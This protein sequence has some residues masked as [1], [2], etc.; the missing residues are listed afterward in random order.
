MRLTLVARNTE[1]VGARLQSRTARQKEAV[2]S[3]MGRSGIRV[4]AGVIANAPRKTGYLASRTT[5]RRTREGFNYGV[6]YY[7]EDF[8]G[9]IGRDGRLI[10]VFYP[11]LLWGGT[12]VM[13]G[14]DWLTPALEA[15]RPIVR[16]N[17]ARILAGTPVE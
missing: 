11:I 5:L 9:Q 16:G 2:K 15:E 14:R 17:L 12:R 8:I 7:A 10:T 1:G 6:G 3:E 13:A 4:L